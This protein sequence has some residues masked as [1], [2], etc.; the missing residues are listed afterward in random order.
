MSTNAANMLK[1]ESKVAIVTGASRGIGRAIAL[2]L[3]KDG[4]NLVLSSRNIK[5]LDQVSK[6]IFEIGKQALVVPVDLLLADSADLIISKTIEH[7]GRLDALVNNSG[8]VK[9]VATLSTL[10][11][12]QWHETFEL[13]FFSVVRLVKAAI[14]L[15]SK[16]E[17]GRIINIASLVGAQPGYYNPHYAASK[18]ALINF[19]KSLSD[20][21]ADKNVLVNV[22]CPGSI[23]TESWE[24][25]ISKIA[26]DRAAPLEETIKSIEEEETR[27]V[28]LRRLGEAEEV[29]SVVSFLASPQSSLMTGSCIFVDGGKRRSIF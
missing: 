19:S 1:S 14:P 18:A 11:L 26:Q 28:P 29:A 23:K 10:S 15:L 9:A 12:D 8:G 16:S 3:A 17:S 7:F 21:L 25:N 13:N 22:V 27:K 2:A 5:S 24:E 6:T 4:Y 20:Q